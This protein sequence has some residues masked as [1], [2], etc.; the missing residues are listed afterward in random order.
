MINGSPLWDQFLALDQTETVG[1]LFSTI[2]IGNNDECFLYKNDQGLPVF[3]REIKEIGS[4]VDFRLRYISVSF[5]IPYKVETDGNTSERLFI[6][7]ICE[8]KSLT[9][10]RVF[11]SALG[12]ILNNADTDSPEKFISVL[13]QLFSSR[14][15]K[16]KSVVGIWGELAFILQSESVEQAVLAWHSDPNQLRDF[17]FVSY[18]VEVK[19]A[20]GSSRTHS[21][22]YEQLSGCLPADL[23]CSIKI[24]QTDLGL[25]CF[26]LADKI[27]DQLE[28]VASAVFWKKFFASIEPTDEDFSELRFNL[29]RAHS[30][31]ML[32]SLPLIAS[33][34]KP[35]DGIGE[36]R[37]IRFDI[38]FD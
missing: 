9:L 37:S 26:E 28:E 20:S 25:N 13:I 15:D 38:N 29:E 4:G 23:L 32:I 10:Q 30:S 3:L 11:V 27:S 35:S 24:E 33:P 21:F 5:G 8:D 14:T 16:K 22:S 36:I 18:S 17:T 7:V 12:S 31:Q 19:T 2:T 1:G 34:V 6:K